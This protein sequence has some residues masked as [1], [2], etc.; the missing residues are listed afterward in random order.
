MRPKDIPNDVETAV[1]IHSGGFDSTTLLYWLLHSGVE[2]KTLTLDYG[3]KMR[4]E[5]E[6]ARAQAELLGLEHQEADLTALTQFFGESTLLD[7]NAN[8]ATGN[9]WEASMMGN[10]VPNRNMI[11]L[12]VGAAWAFST[13]SHALTYGCHEENYA[14]DSQWPFIRAMKDAIWKADWHK[15]KVLTPLMG[16]SKADQVNVGMELGI[17]YELAW[18][19]YRG[20]EVQCG[21]C[22]ACVRRLEG[23]WIAGYED[24]AQY[25]TR[26]A[27][28]VL[29]AKHPDGA[30]RG[31][32]CPECK[33]LG[34]VFDDSGKSDNTLC[35]KCKG[36]GKA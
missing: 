31:D 34:Y 22:G 32:K 28:K 36:G 29:S 25:V 16:M 10:M 13:K 15:V 30:P 1:L 2:V 5:I 11:M 18:S 12:A 27:W 17:P 8:A 24:P 26:E 9:Q 23:F 14:L 33:G 3:Q 19:C 21:E 20:G 4:M 7:G 35:A 6:C